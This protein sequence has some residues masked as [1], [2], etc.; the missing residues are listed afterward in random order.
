MTLSCLPGG[1]VISRYLSSYQVP[2]YSLL[3]HNWHK[4]CRNPR[5][6]AKLG[7][8][9]WR[10]QIS[11]ESKF[12]NQGEWFPNTNG[13]V[14][15]LDNL[16]QLS[17][18]DIGRDPSHLVEWTFSPHQQQQSSLL[19]EARLTLQT[20]Y[21]ALQREFSTRGMDI[22]TLTNRYKE[23]QA[24]SQALRDKMDRMVGIRGDGGHQM[25]W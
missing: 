2:F 24:T 16:I 18:F 3:G 5:A 17:I 20:S 8:N 23:E 11:W 15:V 12:G 14:G 22:E 13:I 10:S 6:P 21:E 4:S 9:D 19:L 7:P 25:G 1:F